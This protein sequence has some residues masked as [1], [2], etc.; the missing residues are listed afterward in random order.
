MEF[1]NEGSGFG[2]SLFCLFPGNPRHLSWSVVPGCRVSSVDKLDVRCWAYLLR[3]RH[4]R[5]VVGRMAIIV[6]VVNN[7]TIVWY[8]WF[9]DGSLDEEMI[10]RRPD[11]PELSLEESDGGVGAGEGRCEVFVAEVQDL[12]LEKSGCGDFKVMA[13]PRE[14]RLGRR[15]RR[16]GVEEVAS[17]G[18]DMG[19]PSGL[20]NSR[21]GIPDQKIQR[22]QGN[23]RGAPVR[24]PLP[25]LL[26]YPAPT[27]CSNRRF[28]F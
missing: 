9:F 25:E 4:G 2:A 22:H 7:K 13:N 3:A 12:G 14:V 16:D 23:V 17:Y 20:G 28:K 27:D 18:F 19:R 6:V 21:S 24:A 8:F 1:S 15:P 5:I 10:R 26:V 11:L